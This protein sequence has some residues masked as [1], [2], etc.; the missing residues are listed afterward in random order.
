MEAKSQYQVLADYYLKHGDPGNALA[1]YRKIS[2]LDPNSINVHV[3]LA[4]LYSQNNQTDEA[5]KEYDRVGTDAAQAR[6]ARRGGAGLQEGAEDRRRA[7]S[8]WSSRSSPRCSRRRTTTTPSQIVQ[9]SL[10]TN[11]RQ[12]A[13]ARDA[14]PHPA[15]EGR[16][17]AARAR[18]SSARSPRDP[19]DADRARGARRSLPPH[20]QRRRRA[21][22]AHAARRE[23]ARR[24]ASAARAVEMLNRVLR[25]DAGHTPT[26]ERLVAR[27][28][29]PQR[30]D[31]HPLV[32]EQ[33]RRGAHR[34]GA[35]R[36][37]R[38]RC[39]RS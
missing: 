4:D 14:R 12:P 10:E 25:V 6:H 5:L 38:R 18:R 28:L 32:D 13:A 1:I 20:R 22:D 29:A 15:G 23:G 2:E 3:K 26:L 8:S 24:A 34:E 36:E 30:R 39:W 9:T 19:N 11:A 27:L 7:T 31:E 37:G 33:P 35:V 16:R 17:A 21:G